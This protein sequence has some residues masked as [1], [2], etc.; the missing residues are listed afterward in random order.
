[1][2]EPN[3]EMKVRLLFI[4]HRAFVEIRLLLSDNR[5]E[6]AS[7]LSDIAELIPGMLIDWHDDHLEKIRTLLTKYQKKHA[8]WGFDFVSRLDKQPPLSF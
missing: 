2:N 8:V 1:M 7:D 5:V 3:E 4:M 6:Q